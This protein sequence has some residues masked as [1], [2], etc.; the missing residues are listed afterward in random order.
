MDCHEAVL[1]APPSV[2]LPF[3]A[4]TPH[5]RG[6]SC[7][8]A[9]PLGTCFTPLTPLP[10]IWGPS[11]SSLANS[12]PPSVPPSPELLLPGISPMSKQS[13]NG[14]GG[15]GWSTLPGPP[16]ANGD[17]PV[18]KGTHL[19]PSGGRPPAA[20]FTQQIPADPTPTGTPGVH[21]EVRPAPSCLPD[22]WVSP[23]IDHL[24]Q[25]SD[26]FVSKQGRGGQRGGGQLAQAPSGGAQLRPFPVSREA[27]QSL[28]GRR[29]HPEGHRLL[30]SSLFILCTAQERCEPCLPL[31]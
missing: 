31:V 30:R 19:P 2:R 6:K 28:G 4:K 8:R 3:P 17:R 25:V 21:S 18:D 13:L 10:L 24:H 1:P 5:I 15:G 16:S 27:G 9:E 22:S 11:D 23:Q 29:S 7:P 12:A 26:S 14:R 20:P